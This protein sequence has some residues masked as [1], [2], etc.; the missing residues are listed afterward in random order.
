MSRRVSRVGTA[1]KPPTMEQTVSRL[2]VMLKEMELKAELRE[3]ERELDKNNIKETIEI[4]RKSMEG[5]KLDV[6]NTMDRLSKFEEEQGR[7]RE[8]AG[9]KNARLEENVTLIGK[10]IKLDLE[11]VL[12]KKMS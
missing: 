6:E 4:I 7:E 10:M 5:L 12:M 3:K 11:W 2:E 1:D 8:G 9:Q